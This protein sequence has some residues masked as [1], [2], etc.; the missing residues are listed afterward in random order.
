MN[1]YLRT[2]DG[3]Y[4]IGDNAFTPFSGLAQTAL[5]DAKFVSRNITRRQFSKPLKKHKAVMPPV[6]VPLGENWAAFEWKFIR[7][8]GWPAVMLRKAADLIGYHDL[9]PIG[10]A[11]GVWN[12]QRIVQDD[13]FAP[14][15]P[16]E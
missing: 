3:I 8:Y 9:L 10:Q 13:Y 14:S 2:K 5:H 15:Q 7:L 11:L 16:A 4:V 12:A 6:V 1:D